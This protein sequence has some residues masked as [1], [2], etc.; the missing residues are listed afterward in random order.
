M[1]SEPSAMSPQPSAMFLDFR[2]ALRVL[3]KAPGFSALVI[4]VLA[5]GIGANTAIFSI[6]N[7]VLLKPL[8][9]EDASRLVVVEDVLRGNESDSVSYPDV[10]DWRAQSKTLGGIAAYVGNGATMTGRGEAV[11]LPIAL[12]TSDLFS[13][14]DAKPLLGRTLGPQDNDKGAEPVAVLSEST[15]AHRFGKAPSIVGAKVTLDGRL[16]TIVGVMPASFQFP[17]GAEPV[18]GWLPIRTAPL[19]GD[20]ADQRGAHFLS[21]IGRLAPSATVDQANAELATISAGLATAYPNSN[22]NRSAKVRP[23][24]DAMVHEYR[25]ALL[26]LLSAVGAVLLIACANVANLMLARATA[27][28]REMA[29]RVAIGARRGML[30]RQLLTER[31]LLAGAGGLFGVLLA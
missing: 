2:Q 30:I 14:L 15:W 4:V 25:V 3:F 6:V 23:L 22:K 21:A 9:F 1:V 8:P 18:E 10:V 20:F 31:V 26:V 29:I 27:R 11:S 19:L 7:G 28:Q 17:I 16:F 24:Q 13:V 5:V 12:T